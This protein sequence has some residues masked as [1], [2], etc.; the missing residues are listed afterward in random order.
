MISSPLKKQ[1]VL[2]K[3]SKHSKNIQYHKVYKISHIDEEIE[4]QLLKYS[5]SLS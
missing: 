4:N 5:R 3:K 2:S 1:Y